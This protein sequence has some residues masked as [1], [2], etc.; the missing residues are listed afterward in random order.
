MKY[1]LVNCVYCGSVY[2]RSCY[3]NSDNKKKAM[4]EDCFVVEKSKTSTNTTKTKTGK[5]ILKHRN[6]TEATYDLAEFPVRRCIIRLPRIDLSKLNYDAHGRIVI[7][8]EGPTANKVA[9]HNKSAYT[10][11]SNT[12]NEFAG[13]VLD[14]ND[15]ATD[16]IEANESE[17]IENQSL[18]KTDDSVIVINDTLEDEDDIEIT[19]SCKSDFMSRF[20]FGSTQS[21]SSTENLPQ[22]KPLHRPFKADRS[23]R[24]RGS[25]ESSSSTT[26]TSSDSWEPIK[27]NKRHRDSNDSKKSSDYKRQRVN[28]IEYNPMISLSDTRKNVATKYYKTTPNKTNGKLSSPSTPDSEDQ[29]LSV[30]QS[31]S[32][33]TS[34]KKEISPSVRSFF[35][36]TLSNFLFDATPIKPPGQRKRSTPRKITPIVLD[37]QRTITEMFNKKQ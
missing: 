25:I 9:T 2:H 8:N 5:D 37:G 31:W 29:S 20:S 23:S 12:Q 30:S 14:V 26:R 28:C 35:G 13:N 19:S 6:K 18:N 17:I 33:Q 7:L 10:I 21:C 15:N 32:N 4:C 24:K 36:T 22:T 34:N 11:T 1:S 16:L 27:S 3:I